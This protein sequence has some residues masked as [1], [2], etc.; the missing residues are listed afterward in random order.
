MKIVLVS[1]SQDM[2][3]LNPDDSHSYIVVGEEDSG[4]STRIPVPLETVQNIA[5]WVEWLKNGGETEEAAEPPEEE[6]AETVQ[7]A[8]APTAPGRKRIP[9]A[10]QPQVLRRAS[11]AV[12]PLPQSEDDVPSV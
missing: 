6:P 10:A 2:N 12:A 1:F 4:E 3:I 8:P 7:A 5:G 9:P 11:T